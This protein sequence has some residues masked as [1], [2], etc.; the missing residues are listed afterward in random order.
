MI[1]FSH[2]KHFNLTP[3]LH[4]YLGGFMKGLVSLLFFLSLTACS[5]YPTNN[6]LSAGTG[7]GLGYGILSNT[8]PLNHTGQN[9]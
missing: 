2:F 6:S 5:S 7:T 3:E 4:A 9:F 1:S 8:Q